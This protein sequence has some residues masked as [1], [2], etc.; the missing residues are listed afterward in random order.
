M[1][2]ISSFEQYAAITKSFQQK[3]GKTRSSNIL[4]PAEVQNAIAEKR[5]FYVELSNALLLL[6]DGGNLYHAYAMLD[7]NMP[8]EVFAPQVDKRILLDVPMRTASEDALA[9]PE[10]CWQSLGFTY[11]TAHMRMTWT[12]KEEV[13]QPAYTLT[14]DTEI[15]QEMVDDW[16]AYLDT[17]ALSVPN[18][19]RALKPD[20]RM[21]TIRDENGRI[22]SEMMA[23]PAKRNGN[24]HTLIT[25]PDQRG[26]GL[27]K[28]M[29][30]GVY[31]ALHEEGVEKLI[32]WVDTTNQSGKKSYMKTGFVFDKMI[33]YQYIM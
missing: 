33:S 23:C 26:K 18:K 31:L 7:T 12:P 3:H 29:M 16:Y 8:A 11:R 22:L 25:V 21:F 5:M 14:R 17:D 19:P 15:T 28:A 4:L 24:L 2:A 1:E 6:I 13:P 27:A 32:L 9:E 10:A 30:A 20:E